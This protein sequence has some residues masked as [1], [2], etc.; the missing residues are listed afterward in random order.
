MD[1]L[2][3]AIEQDGKNQLKKS[4]RREKERETTWEIQSNYSKQRIW[5]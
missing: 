5:G 4:V 2:H 3:L 1:F